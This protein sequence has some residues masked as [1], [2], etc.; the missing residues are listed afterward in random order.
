MYQTLAILA[1]FVL[2]YSSVA[3]RVERSWI[4][5]PIV[6]TIFGLLIGPVGLNLL[7]FETD[8]ETIKTLAELTLALFTDAAGADIGVLRKTKALPIRL[9]LIGLPLR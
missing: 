4:S 9:L 7:S 5:G 3:G 1:L 6:F 2:I 8:R